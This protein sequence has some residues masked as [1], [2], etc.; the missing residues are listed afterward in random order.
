LLE[1]PRGK[2][3]TALSCWSPRL[4]T[5]YF[6][7]SEPLSTPCDPAQPFQ[8]DGSRRR[9][10]FSQANFGIFGRSLECSTRI[11]SH[12]DFKPT[13]G[14]PTYIVASH[15][16]YLHQ[17]AAHDRQTTHSQGAP[18]SSFSRCIV[19]ISVFCRPEQTLKPMLLAPRAPY[20]LSPGNNTPAGTRAPVVC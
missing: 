7:R 18:S 17:R 4:A 13:G 12:R 8:P 2:E 10:R 20:A 15:Y 11:M 16:C 3:A 1:P 14:T 19:D 6:H 5:N 9:D